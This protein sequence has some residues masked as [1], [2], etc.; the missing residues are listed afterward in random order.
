MDNLSL[1]YSLLKSDSEEEIDEILSKENLSKFDT[2]YHK[3]LSGI[4]KLV[5]ENDMFPTL[6]LVNM[7]HSTYGKC[8]VCS[9][10]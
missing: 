9:E 1:F 4:L 3:L 2:A 10:S 7:L 6:N 8:T 5:V